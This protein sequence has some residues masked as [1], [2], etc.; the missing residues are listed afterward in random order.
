MNSDLPFHSIPSS[1]LKI[2]AQNMIARMVDGLAFRYRWA[3]EGLKQEELSFK[4]SEDSMDLER[5]LHHVYDL[6]FRADAK[7]GATIE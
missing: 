2:N 7:F 4:P 5:L 6:C 1:P 3:T